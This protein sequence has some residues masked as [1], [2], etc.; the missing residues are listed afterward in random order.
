MFLR[1]FICN[2][3]RVKISTKYFFAPIIDGKTI[4]LTWLITISWFLKRICTE[5]KGHH[6]LSKSSNEGTKIIQKFVWWIYNSYFEDEDIPEK[7]N[8]RH[9]CNCMI[10]RKKNNLLMKVEIH[11]Q[12][13]TL[14]P[15]LDWPLHGCICQCRSR[16]VCKFNPWLISSAGLAFCKSCLLANTNNGTPFSFGSCNNSSSS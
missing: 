2:L 10:F 5:F 15:S 4:S 12:Q 13:G 3:I 1:W 6:D 11:L 7:P 14:M 9:S 16:I 8:K